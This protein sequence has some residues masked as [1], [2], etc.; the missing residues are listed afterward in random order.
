MCPPPLSVFAP[1]IYTRIYHSNLVCTKA[2]ASAHTHAHVHLQVHTHV[3]ANPHAC[4][5]AGE[6]CNDQLEFVKAMAPIAKTLTDSGLA[7]FT[8]H[9]MVWTCPEEYRGSPEC[10]SQC[11]RDG[12]YCAQVSDAVVQR[13]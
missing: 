4:A 13:V 3:H 11:I 1:K 7:T 2:H 9:Y 6:V 12:V 5:R 8:P 10:E